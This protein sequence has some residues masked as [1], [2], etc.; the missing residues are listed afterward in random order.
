M[1]CVSFNVCSSDT[2]SSITTKI[3]F[4]TTQ[5]NHDEKQQN[6]IL[7]KLFHC[8][9][10]SA[11]PLYTNIGLIHWYVTDG[12]NNS[13]IRAGTSSHA[14][15]MSRASEVEQV[16]FTGALAGHNPS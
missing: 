10:A 12:Q 14:G 7:I 1:I 16:R 5:T 13:P 9:I 2:Y 15:F 3:L 6:Q 8:N 4:L 11:E